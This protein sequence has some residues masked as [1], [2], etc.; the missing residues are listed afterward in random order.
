AR[1]YILCTDVLERGLHRP[2]GLLEVTSQPPG[3][4]VL[5]DGRRVG[6][7]PYRRSAGPGEHEVVVHKTGYLDY[8]NT[9]DIVTNRGSV[10]DA[11]LKKDVPP[12]PP[13]SP[14]PTSQRHSAK[15]S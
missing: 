10:L 5:V 14:P 2:L 1:L 15:R 6:T 9:V 13:P 12:P 3:A 11:M 8:Q 4:E 7:T